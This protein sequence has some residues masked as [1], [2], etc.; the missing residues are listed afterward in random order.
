MPPEITKEFY[1]VAE[2]LGN[3]QI[4]R[5][6]GAFVDEGSD[7]GRNF[8]RVTGRI[9]HAWLRELL[10][11]TGLETKERKDPQGT[12]ITLFT[13][14]Q[15]LALVGDHDLLIAGF[16]QPGKDQ[17]VLEQAL[18]LREK[19]EANAATGG[20]KANLA[21]I[22]AQAVAYLTGEFPEDFRR[23][24]GRGLGAFPKEVSAHLTRTA[25]GFDLIFQGGMDNEDQAKT[26][27]ETAAKL[28]TDGLEAL[29]QAP[30]VPFPGVNLGEIRNVLNSL[31]LE[32]K[33]SAVS[34]RMLLSDSAVNMVPLFLLGYAAVGEVAPPA[35]KKGN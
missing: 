30:E 26:F 32:A 10:K 18:A 11:T 34:V 8:I 6:T 19:S 27:V 28:R 33:G 15:A 1:K 25:N 13:R 5:V 7:K 20:L 35:L 29:K 12:A 4:Q 17:D 23:D 24:V 3:F 16:T 21:K 14:G 9:N 22:P 31:Q 2:S